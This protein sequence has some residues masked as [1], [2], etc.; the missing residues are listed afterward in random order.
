VGCGGFRS[1]PGPARPNPEARLLEGRAFT[2]EERV[3]VFLEQGLRFGGR[4]GPELRTQLGAP[5]EEEV[6]SL[7]ARSPSS[8]AIPAEGDSLLVWRYDGLE[9]EILRTS[10]GRRF[11]LSALVTG[12]RFLT[13]SELG[14]G[15]GEGPL[16]RLLGEGM[17]VSG[18]AEGERRDY[19][20]QSCVGS[21]ASGVGFE[22][23]RGRIERIEFRFDPR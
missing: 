17:P 2:E 19:R 13:F 12:N 21:G 18:G 3:R 9:L 15:Q 23:S 20:C 1:D 8:D 10:E 14:V 7:A 11:L 16:L 5:R 6:R 4:T 22:L